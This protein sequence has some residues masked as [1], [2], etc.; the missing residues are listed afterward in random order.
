[1]QRMKAWRQGEPEPEDWI[2]SGDCALV[3]LPE[4]EYSV[5]LMAHCC[6]VDYGPVRV[7]PLARAPAATSR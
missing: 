1:M 3:K 6:R 5:A 4:R 7:L 2:E